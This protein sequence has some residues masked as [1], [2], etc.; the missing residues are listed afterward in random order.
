MI[1]EPLPR[2]PGRFGPAH[3]GPVAGVSVERV[4]PAPRRP[5][6][7]GVPLVLAYAAAGPMADA[8]A[9]VSPGVSA[10]AWRDVARPVS[11]PADVARIYGPPRD[12]G[13][14]AATMTGFF[15]NG[16]EHAYVV[17]LDPRV[18]E[19]QAVGAALR[20]A[21]DASDIDLLLVPDA[22]RDPE[23]AAAVHQRVLDHCGA[24]GDRF[25]ILDAAPAGSLRD[26]VGHWQQLV[27]TAAALYFPW[28]AVASP[29]GRTAAAPP[30]GH[31]A[32][33][34]ARS[35]R[36]AGVVKAPAN[37]PL[38]GA[39]DLMVETTP[40]EQTAADPA[41]VVNCLRVSAGGGI[42]IWGAR[43][44]SRHGD[45]QH[46]GVRRL[47]STTT[48]WLARQLDDVAYEAND[49]RLW[50]RVRR[51]IN[52]YLF[53]L[54]AAGVLRGR[55]PQEAYVVRCDESTTSPADRDAGRLNIDIGMAAV[56]PAR[57]IIVRYQHDAGGLRA[58]SP[59][60]VA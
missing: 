48:R 53:K 23:Y 43:T 54:F 56:R 13:H 26:G 31:V 2:A 45:W 16:G 24:A 9:T 39:L 18:S 52:D 10:A 25:A 47:F 7:T 57:F 17:R 19:V 28:I 34:Y 51:E 59:A 5:L 49:T 40:E 38:A 42:R 58:L 27:G 15:A 41:G 37:E 33:V 44:T 8:D 60:D 29:A 20:L 11:G 50:A 32:G 22:W 3:L 46:V 30:C 36:L 21:E 4:V 55:S 6:Q 12:G 35:D 1:P 14:L